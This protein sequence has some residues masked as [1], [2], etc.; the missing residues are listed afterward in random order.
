V[1]AITTPLGGELRREAEDKGWRTL[2]IPDDL[3]GRYSV[4]TPCG[5][6][7]LAVA[8]ADIQE[9]V[10]GYADFSAS[11]VENA[12]CYAAARQALASSGYLVE[13]LAAWEPNLSSIG[14]WWQQLYA[15]SEGK[16]GKGIFPITLEYPADLHSIGQYMQEGQ[17]F[18][19][20]TMF[21]G[22]SGSTIVIP[23]SER[24][25]GELNLIAGQPFDAVTAMERRSV[26]EA[27][28]SG[29]MPIIDMDIGELTAYNMGKTLKFFMRSC[30][31]SGYVQGVNPFDQKGVELY[32][33]YMMTAFR[34]LPQG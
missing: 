3:Q 32:K 5:L 4:L 24:D 6:L 2:S 23:H 8:G 11:D 1:I 29:G 15:E 19:F 14:A 21:Y 12:I 17:K 34:A 27:H 31:I 33:D 20:E 10:D 28:I 22:R 26:I 13:A 7:P 18:L 9:L 16:E 30:G 25:Y